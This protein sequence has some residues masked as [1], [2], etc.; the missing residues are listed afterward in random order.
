[1]GKTTTILP[2]NRPQCPDFLNSNIMQSHW[3]ERQTEWLQSINKTAQLTFPLTVLSTHS[4]K[5]LISSLKRC[6]VQV[7]LR[8][9]KKHNLRGV[10]HLLFDL[11]SLF[12]HTHLHHKGLSVISL[13]RHH[14]HQSC[15]AFGCTKI[16]SF[17]CFSFYCYCIY[18]EINFYF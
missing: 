2:G 10:I 18:V 6:K 4:V 9:D 1:M 16:P 12:C 14:F 13:F 3:K 5:L 8:N 11:C 17:F 15:S 7:A